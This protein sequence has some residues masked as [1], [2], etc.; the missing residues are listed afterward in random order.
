MAS[1]CNL[2]AILACAP[3]V[4]SVSGLL[5][6]FIIQRGGANIGAGKSILAAVAN[7]P[8]DITLFAID[9][10]GSAGTLTYVVAV[11]AGS[12]QTII[13][14]ATA[15]SEVGADIVLSEIMG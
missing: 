4:L 10:P 8:G 1:A 2:V 3:A 13:C 14:P 11:K 5:G 12:G 15:S 7:M 6:S 9:R